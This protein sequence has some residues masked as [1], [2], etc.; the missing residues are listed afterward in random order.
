MCYFFYFQKVRV[1]QQGVEEAAAR[2]TALEAARARWAPPGDSRE[3]RAQAAGLR[4]RPAP[5]A[6]LKDLPQQAVAL[7]RARIPVASHLI[8]ALDDLTARYV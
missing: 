1:F 6:A 5:A 2:V 8:L 7:Q 3:A 4:A